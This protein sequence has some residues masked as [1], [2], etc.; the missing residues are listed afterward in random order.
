MLAGGGSICGQLN[1]CE[2]AVVG[3]N[4]HLESFPPAEGGFIEEGGN[5]NDNI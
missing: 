4:R 1:S 2:A 5:T 3:G